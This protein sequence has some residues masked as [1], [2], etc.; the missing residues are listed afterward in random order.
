M[1][2]KWSAID[3]ENNRLLINHTVVG[4]GKRVVLADNTKNNSSRRTLTYGDDMKQ[5]FLSLKAHQEEMKK[6]L[7]G[8]Y[9]DN[10]YVCRWDTGKRMAPEYVSK[11][12]RKLL[13]QND[14]PLIRFHDLRHSVASVLLN[15]GCD[16]KKISTWLGHCD[17]GTT[18]NIYAH[19]QFESKVEMGN[20]LNDVIFA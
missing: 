3:L 5:Y 11:A 13:V 15:K 19:L 4:N 8:G 20:I 1:G 12:F 18:A 6:L 17:I 16:L 9:I 2:L 14:L 7:G 10:E